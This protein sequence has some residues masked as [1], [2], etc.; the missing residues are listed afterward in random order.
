MKNLQDALKDA[1]GVGGAAATEPGLA[2]R[3]PGSPVGLAALPR[4][5]GTEW[6]KLL[7]AQGIRLDGGASVAAW[8]QKTAGAVKALEAA[9]RRHDARALASARDEFV[10]LREKRAWEAIKAR[11]E[12]LALPE[13]AYRAVKQE[14]GDAEK[15]LARLHTRKAEEMKGI[16][17]AR[18]RDLLLGRE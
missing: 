15:M 12:A 14:G 3:E 18:V 9:G 4:P 16:A 6:E 13:K 2:A 8:V 5:E 11:F 7:R 1:L 17:A 10:R